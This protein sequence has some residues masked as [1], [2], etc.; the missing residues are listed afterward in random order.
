MSDKAPAWVV[1]VMRAGYAA[2]GIVYTVVGGLALLAAVRGGSAEGTRDALAE[3]TSKSWGTALLWVIGIGL[4]CYAA[5]RLID[6]WMDLD[7]LG[8]DAKG[9]VGRIGQ[10]VT[11]IIHAGLGL[12]AIKLAM[13]GESGGSGGGGGEGGSD[14]AETMTAKVLSWPGGP[15]IVGA[16]ALCIIGAGIYYA[17]KGYSGKY[18]KHISD[19]DMTLKLDPMMKGGLIAQ[20]VVIGMVGIFIL[21]A[22]MTLNPENAGGVGQ[23]LDQIRSFAFG[24]ILLGVMAVG[25]LFFALENYVQ[26]IYR[27]L[28]RRAGD[29]VST[30]AKRVKARAEFE[31]RRVTT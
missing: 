7:N 29:D 16:A 5:W 8:T 19:T 12:S 23:A 13:G 31:A 28:P 4:F 22:A 20:G 25:L 6:A 14:K 18:R 24:R 26:S 1:P 2:R 15:Y 9:I 21:I 3:L 11:G 27:I 10:V 17:Y 30:L